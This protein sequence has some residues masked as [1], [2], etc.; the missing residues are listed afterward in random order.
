MKKQLKT[1]FFLLFLISEISFAQNKTIEFASK[2]GVMVTADL[3]LIED[4]KAPFVILFHQAG[5]SR[6]EYI[7]IAPKLNNLGFNCMAIDQRSGKGVNGIKN[8]T[9]K[10]ATALNKETK[11]P[12]AIP[13]IEA[14]FQ[15]V[16]NELNAPKI[17]IWGSSYSAAL[18]LYLGSQHP[19]ELAGIL[20]FSPG[21]YFKIDGNEIKSYTSKITCPVFITSA[22][23]EHDSWKEMYDLI[24]SEKSYFLPEVKGKHGSKALWKENDEHE[25][26]WKAVKTFLNSIN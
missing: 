25:D 3:Y 15:Y 11:Y 9:K 8:K 16:K 12:D 19:N 4:T 24:P 23:N 21:E 13:D 6:G 14:A 20:S 17:I 22:K 5:Y 10:S 26:Y 18:V 2:D 7:E 1:I